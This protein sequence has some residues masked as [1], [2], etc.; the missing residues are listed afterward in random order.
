MAVRRPQSQTNPLG[1]RAPWRPDSILS[2]APIARHSF[3]NELRGGQT[4]NQPC[5]GGT[6]QTLGDCKIGRLAATS[7]RAPHGKA[8]GELGQSLRLVDQRSFHRHQSARRRSGH[9][10]G[11]SLRLSGFLFLAALCWGALV[12][13]VP[14]MAIGGLYCAYSRGN[15]RGALPSRGQKRRSGEVSMAT[16]EYS[17]VLALTY[18]LG[19][20]APTLAYAV[21]AGALATF[22][23]IRV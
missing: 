8:L 21:L 18:F 16:M 23:T 5:R 22:Q 3:T 1:V 11:Q 4:G 14:H 20:G 17:P 19:P 12:A 2:G 10:P 7:I 9:V 15:D 13:N 6:Q